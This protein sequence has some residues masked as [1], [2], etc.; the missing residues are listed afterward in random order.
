MEGLRE[1]VR[2]ISRAKNKE[3]SA[4]LRD[5]NQ[6]AAQVVVPPARA[7]APSLSGRLAKSVRA[8]RDRLYGIVQ[9]GG[10]ARVPY[11]G[12]THFGW[13]RRGQRANRFVWR[14]LAKNRPEVYR[15]YERELQRVAAMIEDAG[16]RR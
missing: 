2:A 1:V 6:R 5:A 7:E 3:L 14:A 9:V 8:K 10:T 11:A 12:P 13:P 16:R 15:V 4:A